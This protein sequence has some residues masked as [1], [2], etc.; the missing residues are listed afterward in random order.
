M[1]TDNNQIKVLALGCKDNIFVETA[2][3]YLFGRLG[4]NL[5]FVKGRDGDPFPEDLGWLEFDYLISLLSPW[6]VPEFLL[7][8]TKRAAINFHLG[9]PEYPGVSPIHFALYDNVDSY[10]VTCH[11]IDNVIYY[12][13]IIKVTRFKIGLNESPES[14][15]KKTYSYM[16]TLFYRVIDEILSGGELPLA[17]GENW[18]NKI[19]TEEE[20]CLLS[21]LSVDMG[22]KEF[23]NRI[24]AFSF[25]NIFPPKLIA[26]GH[27][28]ILNDHH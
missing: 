13:V 11:Y 18:S 27:T 1:H 16:T 22:K 25:S 19:R 7:K 17:T 15:L 28:F 9:P 6:V 2:N 10:G 3:D 20:L 4:E 21:E 5:T 12:G 8:K 24:R 26:F 23:E 14:V